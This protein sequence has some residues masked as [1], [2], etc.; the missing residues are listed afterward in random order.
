MSV[1]LTYISNL[2]AAET[3]TTGVPAASATKAVVTHDAWNTTATTVTLAAE[4]PAIATTKI[5][6]FEQALAAGAATIDLE[7][8]SGTNGATV[9][10]TGLRIQAMKVRGKSTN[11]DPVSITIGAAN[12]YDGF[13]AAFKVTLE[14]GAEMMILAKDAGADISATN[15]DL[16]C[17]GTGVEIILG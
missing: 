6:A 17:A 15:S 3:L 16:D 4:T 2:T 11:D 10:G 14:P 9:V 12:G 5:A 8:L 7:A 13:G 1:S